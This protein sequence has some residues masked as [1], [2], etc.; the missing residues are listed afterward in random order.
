[1]S[2]NVKSPW[3]SATRNAISKA[4]QIPNPVSITRRGPKAS[5]SAPE[6]HAATA[7]TNP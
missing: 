6:S 4:T 7:T 3:A 2:M 1:M 5:A